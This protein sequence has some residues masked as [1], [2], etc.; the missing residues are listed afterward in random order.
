MQAT[1]R[2]IAKYDIATWLFP[3]IRFIYRIY[4]ACTGWSADSEYRCPYC[5]HSLPSFIFQFCEWLSY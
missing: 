2:D 1:L 4:A 5:R 3:T